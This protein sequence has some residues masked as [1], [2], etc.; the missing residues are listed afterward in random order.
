MQEKW[1]WSTETSFY[2]LICWKVEQD[3]KKRHQKKVNFV[4]HIREVNAGI[5][6]PAPKTPQIWLD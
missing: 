4:A 1:L 2:Q 6:Q 5:N 3:P